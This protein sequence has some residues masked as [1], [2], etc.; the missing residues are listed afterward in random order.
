MT[1]TESIGAAILALIAVGGL[2][3]VVV[4]GMRGCAEMDATR[5]RACGDTCGDRG[6]LIAPI[7]SRDQC[8]CR[9]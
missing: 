2:L 9:P 7:G 1:G 8:V 4:F 3:A 5:M 6:V